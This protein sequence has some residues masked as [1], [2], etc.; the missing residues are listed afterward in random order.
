MQEINERPFNI[1]IDTQ[2][3]NWDVT[4]AAIDIMEFSPCGRYL[5]VR[6]QLYPTTVWIWDLVD[7]CVDYL[8][9]KNSISGKINISVNVQN[10]TIVGDIEIANFHVSGISWE[11]NN[12]RLLVSSESSL[13]FEWRPRRTATSFESPK[14]MKVLNSKWNPQGEVLALQGYNKASII[15]ITD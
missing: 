4:I 11:S 3:I 8:L 15:R 7:D 2:P 13:L 1:Q 9:L 12:T 14:A 10:F 6:H 5:A